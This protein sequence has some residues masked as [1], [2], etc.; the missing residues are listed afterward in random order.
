M[1]QMISPGLRNRLSV[2]TSIKNAPKIRVK[3]TDDK[4]TQM[5]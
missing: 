2:D 1:Q 3:T 5:L 4:Y